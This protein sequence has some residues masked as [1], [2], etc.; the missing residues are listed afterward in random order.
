MLHAVLCLTSFQRALS[1]THFLG[2]EH[3]VSFDFQED[4]ENG[5]ALLVLPC[6]HFF[7]AACITQ[8]FQDKNVCPLCKQVVVSAHC[9]LVATSSTELQ[10]GGTQLATLHHSIEQQQ[11]YLDTEVHDTG[12]TMGRVFCDYGTQQYYGLPGNVNVSACRQSKCC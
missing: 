8:W 11:V 4:F 12:V 1:C 7:H 9:S 3:T 10:A 6:K 5:E 2:V